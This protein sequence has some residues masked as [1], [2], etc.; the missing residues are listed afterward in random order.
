MEIT[1]DMTYQRCELAVFV[2]TPHSILENDV[3]LG[4][5]SSLLMYPHRPNTI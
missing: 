5:S 2:M 3:K 4:C 1:L